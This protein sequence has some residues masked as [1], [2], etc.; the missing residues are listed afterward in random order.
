MNEETN[1][2]QAAEPLEHDL[3]SVSKLTSEIEKNRFWENPTFLF[4][5]MGVLTMTAMIGT[6]FIAQKYDDPMIVI[7]SVSFVA[8][9][10]VLIGGMIIKTIDQLSAANRMKTEFVSIASHQLRTPLS[11]IKWYVEF[12]C[13]KEEQAKFD[14][15]EK[16]YIQT[17]GDANQRMIRLVNDLLDIS[18]VESGKIVI[19]PQPL[20][21]VEMIS[22]IIAE[23]RPLV[24]KQGIRINFKSD[25]AVPLVEAD[26]KRISMAIDNLISNAVKYT[27]DDQKSQISLELSREGKK[28]LFTIADNGVGIPERDKKKIFKKFFRADNIMKLQTSGTGLG[29]FIAK[30]I[31]ESHQGKIWF[32][33]QEGAGTTF[34]FNLP[35]KRH[36]KLPL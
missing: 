24:E 23:Y 10:I 13:K 28:V 22:N 14:Q 17:I 7:G 15:K 29:L 26:P 12:L 9:I 11:I 2:P 8:G 19:R 21:L 33:S 34:Y 1:A 4:V 25:Q 32:V 20:N 36:K 5:A 3:P 16:K 31:I 35:L 27:Q 30:A 6:Y 18:R